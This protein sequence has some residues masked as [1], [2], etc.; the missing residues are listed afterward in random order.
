MSII[1]DHPT[2]GFLQN[3]AGQNVFL[4]LTKYVRD[5]TESYFSRD[6]G[7]LSILD[8]GCGKGHVTYLLRKLGARPISCDLKCDRGDSSFG[9][10]VPIIIDQGLRVE[11]LK[12]EYLLPFDN[13][14][15]DIV[16]GFGVLEHVPYD[17]NSLMEINRILKQGGIFFCF[18]LP[19]ILSWTQRLCRLRGDY[20]HDRLYNKRK[21][22]TMLSTSGFD[23]I[24]MWHRQLFPKN[25]I[26]YPK[27]KLFERMDHFLTEYTPLKY[28][29]TNIEFVAAKVNDHFEQI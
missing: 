23:V 8:W 16:L 22:N 3:P 4:Y 20:Y 1:K 6:I 25:T 17:T 11:P 10:D 19:Y 18:N 15:M 12:H 7:Q 28:F 29:A 13:A 27:Y 14:S 21:V 9:Q 24:D 5:F 26:H 2:H